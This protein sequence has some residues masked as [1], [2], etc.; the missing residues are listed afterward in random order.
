MSKVNKDFLKFVKQKKNKS[1]KQYEIDDYDESSSNE[2]HE[3]NGTIMNENNE[4]EKVY[5]Y[6]VILNPHLGSRQE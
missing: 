2:D 5:I 1:N 3:N 6:N 4:T